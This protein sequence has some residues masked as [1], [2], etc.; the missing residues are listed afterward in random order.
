MT[1]DLSQFAQ[2]ARVEKINEESLF[3]Y[4][5]NVDDCSCEM[6]GNLIVTATSEMDA[7]ENCWLHILSVREEK[8]KN[9]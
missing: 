1:E 6:K 3:N 8:I 4:R 2:C 9:N 7:I 5:V